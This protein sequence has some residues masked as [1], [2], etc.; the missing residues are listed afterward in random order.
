MW[1]AHDK[2]KYD[3]E[4]FAYF[5][6]SNLDDFIEPAGSQMLELVQTMKAKINADFRSG[7]RLDNGQTE[8]SYVENI[9][10]AGG[11]NGKMALPETFK[12]GIP[13][14]VGDEEA[15]AFTARFRY[16][17]HSG[18][19]KL[20]Y[21]LVRPQKRVEAAENAMADKI[22]IATGMTIYKAH[23]HG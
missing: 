17:I 22:S 11:K 2:E 19:L 18:K 14:F 6:E 12:L 9:E 7:I 8:F 1:T 21:E 20:W 15:M 10:G 16:R 23:Y 13:I 5:I 3:Q 4:T